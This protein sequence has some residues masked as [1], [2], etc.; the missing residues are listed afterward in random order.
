MKKIMNNSEIIEIEKHLIQAEIVEQLE[1]MRSA[2]KIT[3]KD[4]AVKLGVKNSF[5]SQLYGANKFFNLEHLAKIQHFLDVKIN[6]SFTPKSEIRWQQNQRKFRIEKESITS[7]D[8]QVAPD[9]QIKH[10]LAS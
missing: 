9:I 4:L 3:K 8:T 7:T 10:K 2:N 1:R 5:I 6:I